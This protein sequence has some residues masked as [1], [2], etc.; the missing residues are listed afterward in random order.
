MPSTTSAV[1]EVTDVGDRLENP[2]AQPS[3]PVGLGLAAWLTIVVGSM[4]GPCLRAAFPDGG[5][6]RFGPLLIGWIVHRCRNA[7]AGLHLSDAGSSVKPA[8]Y[9][10]YPRPGSGNY[11][12]FTSAF[13]YWVSPG[14]ATSPYLV[15]LFATVGNFIPAFEGGTTKIAIL[16]ASVL[17]WILHALTLRGIQTAAFVNTRSSPSPRWCRSSRSS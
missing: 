10:V 5:Q 12:G 7:D 3:A 14:W 9:A 13:G 16:F 8:V 2:P 1:P 4:I 11:I 17:L 6:R 15:L